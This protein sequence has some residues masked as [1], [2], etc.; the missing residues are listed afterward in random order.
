MSCPVGGE[1]A[2]GVGKAEV[3]EEHVA[4]VA[5]ACQLH[6]GFDSRLGDVVCDVIEASRGVLPHPRGSL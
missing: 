4:C 1:R 5:V 6:N 2:V 3:R